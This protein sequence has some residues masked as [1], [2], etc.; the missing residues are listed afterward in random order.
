[1][2]AIKGQVH[3]ICLDHFGFN[4]VYTTVGQ[5]NERFLFCQVTIQRLELYTLVLQCTCSCIY[6]NMSPI[7]KNTLSPVSP[8]KPISLK[9]MWCKDCTLFQAPSM[10]VNSNS[11]TKIR[12]LSEQLDKAMPSYGK[13]V[14]GPVMLLMRDYLSHESWL[15]IEH[16]RTIVS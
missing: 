6:W 9:M 4:S 5:Q 16:Q 8:T 13:H 2:L 14:Q 10:I 15:A 7:L 12:N 1:M 3:Q 11:A